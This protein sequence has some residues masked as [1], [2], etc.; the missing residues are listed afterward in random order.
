MSK[1]LLVDYLS[2]LGNV[3]V[4]DLLDKLM[5]AV[6]IEDM[7]TLLKAAAVTTDVS[8]LRIYDILRADKRLRQQW[9]SFFNK[10]KPVRTANR[11]HKGSQI[12]V[13]SFIANKSSDPSYKTSN[14]WHKSIMFTLNKEMD[15]D[16][17]D[18]Y[19]AQLK[20][21]IGRRED[22]TLIPDSLAYHIKH[23]NQEAFKTKIVEAYALL[24]IYINKNFIENEL[25][26][27]VMIDRSVKR[28]WSTEAYNE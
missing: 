13:K 15:V 20:E 2:I 19:I 1:V 11:I 16:N 9:F 27:M 26:N 14:D 10:Q 4:Q 22:R 3:E 6:T 25:N 28:T 8:Y 24:G 18:A 12:G 7:M 5:G 23:G 21:I 17:E